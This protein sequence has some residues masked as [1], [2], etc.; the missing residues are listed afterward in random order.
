M[1]KIR[2][3]FRLAPGQGLNEYDEIKVVGSLRISLKKE[4]DFH[5]L[6]VEGF[7]SEQ[8]ASQFYK[9]IDTGLQYIT[10]NTGLSFLFSS[11]L[12]KVA[13]SE[14]PEETRV[15]LSNSLNIKIEEPVDGIID[16]ARPAIYLTEKNIRRVAA[17]NLTTTLSRSSKKFLELFAKSARFET[18]G[19]L[20]NDEKLLS[21]IELYS[22]HFLETTPRAKFLTLVMALE[23]IAIPT[24]RTDN[25]LALIDKWKQEADKE[26]KTLDKK[27]DEYLSRLFA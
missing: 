20:R 2:F 4:L 12:Q 7:K 18:P 26:L 27:S 3:P 6:H 9:K 19:S 15:N 1:Y 24:P 16:A 25:V 17:G 22:G 13:H 14:N 11:G 23:T 5:C 10:L 8:E 21:A